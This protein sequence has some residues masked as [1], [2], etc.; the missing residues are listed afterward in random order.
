M[1]D[2]PETLIEKIIDTET[3]IKRLEEQK[4][5]LRDELEAL[6]LAGEI[7]PSFSYN[8]WSFNRSE[9]RRSYDY[10]PAVKQAEADVKALKKASEA[11]G[12]ATLKPSS[13]FW[14]IKAP[15]P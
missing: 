11:D 10:P 6:C 7:D 5:T 12:T 14:T 9:G 13:P 8:D 4:E 3:A 15:R 2:S 1:A